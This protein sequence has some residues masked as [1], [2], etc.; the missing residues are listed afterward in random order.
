MRVTDMLFWI[1]EREAI[2]EQRAA[3]MPPPWSNDP[4][5]ANT[6]WCNVHRE[7][8]KV[9]R[10]M[11][12]NWSNKDSPLWW[13]VAGRML[14]YIPTLEDILEYGAQPA[15][16]DYPAIDGLIEGLKARRESGEKIFTSAYTI[17]TAGRRMDKLDYVGKVLEE[18]QSLDNRN[19]FYGSTLE[20]FHRR[21]TYVDGLGSFLAAQVVADLKNTPGHPLQMAPDR[22][23]F[24]APGPGSLRG[25]A[26]FWGRPVT[27]RTFTEDLREAWIQCAAVDP[28]VMQ[29]I[30]MQDF[31]NCMCEFSKYI[32]IKEEGGH[33]RNRYVPG[34][35]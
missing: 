11:R 9:T 8:D 18:V 22:V 17:S 20:E 25:L 3:G 29:G 2:R 28:T 31:Q 19:Y 30:D 21:L 27:P 13:F 24:A 32:R 34:H 4:V 1:H 6:R 26:A 23:T 12:E 14:N 33:A 15:T 7:D 35:D 10:F 5:M 16:N